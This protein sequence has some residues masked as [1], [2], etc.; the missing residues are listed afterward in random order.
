MKSII[1]KHQN[2]I[3]LNGAVP[4]SSLLAVINFNVPIIAA[5]G[6]YQKALGAGFK[7]A[8][9]VGDGDSLQS[10]VSENDSI[11]V[12]IS[13][14]DTTD[15]E[16]CIL[17][18][19]EQGLGSSLVLGFSGGEIDHILGNTQALLKHAQHHKLYFLDAYPHAETLTCGFKVG[20]PLTQGIQTFS[21]PRA[22][23]ISIIPFEPV[24]I[25][26]C[27]LRWNLDGTPLKPRG[28]LALRNVNSETNVFFEVLSGVAL[29]VA[30]VT[31]SF[32]C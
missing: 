30:D 28:V 23:C 16:K 22:T 4:D 31:T 17:F 6:A 21:F 20:I 8:Y 15:F 1:N 18:A 7:P 32:K 13:D 24:A 3:F 27:G 10:G 29:L 11:F 5:D 2:I 25:R 9:V 14:Q 26:T 12:K 19:R